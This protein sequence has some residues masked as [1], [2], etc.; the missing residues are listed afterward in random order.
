M[1]I[2]VMG[3]L[4]QFVVKIESFLPFNYFHSLTAIIRCSGKTEEFNYFENFL[5]SLKQ[6]SFSDENVG[7]E[8]GQLCRQYKKFLRQTIEF[9]KNIEMFELTS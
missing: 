1:Q 7:I 9:S 5:L 3:K 2:G 8:L 6:N 4:F